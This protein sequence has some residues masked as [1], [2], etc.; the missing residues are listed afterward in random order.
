M[1]IFTKK[2]LL[3]FLLTLA[4]ASLPSCLSQTSTPATT[5]T[6][7]RLSLPIDCT[8]GKD[9]HILS[10]TDRDPSKQF[11]DF[12]CGRQ[13][14]DGHDGTDFGIPDEKTMKKG[15]AVKAAAAGKI[16][17]IRDGVPDKRIENPQQAEAISK[18]GCGNAVVIDHP[19]GWRTYYC[20][21]R[22]GSVTVKPGMQVEKGTILGMVGSSGLASFPHVHLGVLYKGKEIDPFLGPDV[23]KGC[24]IKGRPLWEQP[25]S[26]TPT[27][28]I[29]A[30]FTSQKPDINAIWQG[31]LTDNQPTTQSPALIFWVHPFGLLQGDIEHHRLIAPDGTIAAENKTELKSPNR[32]NGFSFIGKRNNAD[33]PLTAGTWRGE[34][35]L[36]RGEKILI[37]IKQQIELP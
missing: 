20:H 27:G 35:Q 16:Q 2:H 12:G 22:N 32:I 23:E 3:T 18:I 17:N 36:R 15:V 26:Y 31:T 4:L 21:L 28:L 33:K 13:T 11:I 9:C 5:D 19:N 30:G 7:L 10:Y 8:L 37:D 14:Y 24:N 29:K 6:G 25:I 1:K 34:Y